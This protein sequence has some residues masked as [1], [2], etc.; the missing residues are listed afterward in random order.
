MEEVSVRNAHL[1]ITVELLDLLL[2][3]DLVMLVSI[4][5]EEQQHPG[6]LE[7]E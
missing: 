4:A 6:L 2:Q 7:L 1:D 3:L 5:Q